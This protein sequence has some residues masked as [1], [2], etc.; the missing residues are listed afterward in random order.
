MSEISNYSFDAQGV[1]RKFASKVR[2]NRV[3]YGGHERD[4]EEYGRFFTFAGDAPIFM[5]AASDCMKNN[6]CYQAKRGVLQS[7]IALTPGVHFGGKKDGYGRWF[8]NAGDILASWHHGYMDYT[9]SDVSSYFPE[10]EIALEVYPLQKHDGY[11]VHY[12]IIADA[13]IFFCAILGGMT[14]Y[15]GRFDPME[16]SS[17]D[18]QLS[19]CD[20]CAASLKGNYGRLDH[21]AGK[22]W[23]I[24]GCNFNA[25]LSTDAASAAM[26]GSPSRAAIP[27][28]GKAAILKFIRHLAPG[29]RLE[30]DL[31]VL[32]NGS[33]EVLKYYLETDR[34]SEIVA[35]I[36]SKYNGIK[37][38]TPDQRLNATVIDQQIALD[39]AYHAPTFFH[40]AIGYH[41][42]FLGW[43]GWYG[44][45]LAGWFERMRMATRA[46]LATQVKKNGEEK[47]WYDGADRPDLDHEG[48]QYHHLLNSYGKLTAMLYM[49]D[50][51]DMQEVFVDMVLHYLERS[52]DLELGSEIFDAMSEILAWEERILDPDNDGL[53]QSFLNTWISDGHVYNGGGC[54][55]ASCYNFAANTLMAQLGRKIGRDTEVFVK[56]AEKIRNAVNAILWQEDKG[57]FAEYID[58]IG[59]KLLHPAP[60]LSTIYLASESNL[61]TPEQ[62]EHSLE[63]TEKYIRSVTTINRNGRLAYSSAWLPKKYSTCGLFTA[64]NAALALAYFRCFRKGAALQLLD[65]LLDA[66]AMS[67]SPGGIS[68]VLTA[69]GTGDGGDWD[70]TDVSSPYL[71]TL[72]EGLWGV[73]FHLLEDLLEIAPQLPDVWDNASME[74]PGVR[75]EYCKNSAGMVLTV[76]TSVAGTKKISFAGNITIKSV[77]A[78]AEINTGF[79]GSTPLTTVVWQNCGTLEIV[80]SGTA[81][82]AAAPALLTGIPEAPQRKA[83]PE[84]L[85]NVDLSKVFNVELGKIFEQKYLSPRPAGYSIGSRING[86]YAWEWNHFGHN[87]V[88]VNDEPLRNAPGGVFTTNRNWSFV[89]PA[90]GNNAAC[91]SVWDNFPTSMDVE[92]AGNANE[93]VLFM[94]GSTNAMQS[95]VVN[96]RVKVN[97]LDGTNEQCDLIEQIN[98]DDIMVPAFQQQ[99]ERF[100]WA[101]GN[102]GIIVRIPLDKTRELAGF[103]VEAVA[104][105]VIAG[106]L[107]AAL[108]R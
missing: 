35:G 87:E 69:K 50:I 94:F 51:Y 40:G 22:D 91:V 11:L 43:R 105:E 20:D 37:M 7:G 74:I 70:F 21:T 10:K 28:D 30:G 84:K 78:A 33:E 56:R 9:L 4:L 19:D 39:A 31:V 63:Y 104:N 49:E 62:M 100:Y 83:V 93:L 59:N 71:R 86:R 1:L 98:F 17:R 68:H 26:E 60:E 47:V 27:H 88:V 42:P 57:V 36:R 65:G 45:S 106:L 64:E 76:N 85:E 58:T 18:F 15:I 102:H 82:N 75:I 92:L 77:S 25:E 23:V 12:N 54:T 13:E 90:S 34:R 24:A 6:W 44:G 81:A 73:R 5:G 79:Y 66:F 32:Y 89:T 16:S 41:A 14:D 55:Q 8:H 67:Q 38:Q 53:Y 48:T 29:E 107:G 99:F 46:H 95:F 108:A 3:L 2:F 80:Y 96:A 61:A 72:V 103:T 52:C 97:Y 101:N